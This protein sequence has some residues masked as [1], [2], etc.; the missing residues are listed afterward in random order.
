MDE[1]RPFVLPVVV[2]G[3]RPYWPQG[4]SRIDLE[5]VSSRTFGNGVVAVRYRVVRPG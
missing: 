4:L 2:G 5:Q 1:Y 3:G